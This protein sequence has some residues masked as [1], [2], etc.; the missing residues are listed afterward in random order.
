MVEIAPEAS[1]FLQNLSFRCGRPQKSRK[2]VKR[3]HYFCK[4]GAPLSHFRLLGRSRLFLAFLPSLLRSLLRPLKTCIPFVA[5][6]KKSKK[7]QAKTLLLKI[8]CARIALAALA[9]LA[10]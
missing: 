9:A 4:F 7:R 1:W 8:R 3:K 5:V 10:A 6:L 2:N